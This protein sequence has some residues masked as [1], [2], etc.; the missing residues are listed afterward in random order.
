MF[1][2]L[3]RLQRVINSAARLVLRVRRR[4]HMTR[5]LKYLGWLPIAKR[6]D[7]KLAVNA[8]RCLCRCADRPLPL[9]CMNCSS[10]LYLSSLLRFHLPKRN[11]P[12]ATARTLSVPLSRT[13]THG[14]RAF[15]R[16]CSLVWNSLP[17]NVTS[18]PTISVFR[19]RLKC[20][21]LELSYPK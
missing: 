4:D 9:R 2:L 21:L 17:A 14:D 6:I 16:S 12:S 19:S 11:L 8:Y 3:D 7:Y 15:S 18:A 13:I 10:P 1:A 20:H 5:H